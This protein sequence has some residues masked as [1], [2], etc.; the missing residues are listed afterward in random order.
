MEHFL[1]AYPA[2]KSPP[3]PFSLHFGP[4]L[5]LVEEQVVW[6]KVGCSLP[7]LTFR[8]GRLF[9]LPCCRA[10][11]LLESV[12]LN[13]FSGSAVEWGMC[14]VSGLRP[15]PSEDERVTFRPEG[16]HVENPFLS[17]VIGAVCSLA[18]GGCVWNCSGVAFPEVNDR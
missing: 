2:S 5:L 6:V 7:T 16:I 1:Q 9:L 13:A 4:Y 3:H 8:P 14:P 15:N 18:S 11:A 10:S 17:V 12:A